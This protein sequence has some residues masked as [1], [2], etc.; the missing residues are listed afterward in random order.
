MCTVNIENLLHYEQD[1]ATIN[2]GGIC[3]WKI[4]QT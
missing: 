1:N 3:Y 2:F 4:K